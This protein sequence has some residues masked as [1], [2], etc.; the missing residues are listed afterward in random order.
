MELDDKFSLGQG[1][2]NKRIP[3]LHSVFRIKPYECTP[4]YRFGDEVQTKRLF[5]CEKA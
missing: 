3:S 2:A 1:M 5:S 4:S